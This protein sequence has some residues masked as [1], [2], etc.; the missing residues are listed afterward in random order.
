VREVTGTP[1]EVVEEARRPGD[2]P[3][4]FADPA[5]IEREIGWRASV[6]DLHTIIAS[7]YAWFRDHPTGYGA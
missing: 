7:A 4:L 3:R 2:P 1:F 6:T 5:R